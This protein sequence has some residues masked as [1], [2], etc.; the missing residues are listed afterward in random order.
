MVPT[1]QEKC[2]GQRQELWVG[3]GAGSFLRA[4]GVWGSLHAWWL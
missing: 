4:G 1:L 2:E 3:K